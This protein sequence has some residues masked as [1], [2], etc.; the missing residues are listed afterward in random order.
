MF[1]YALTWSIVSRNVLQ[2][3]TIEAVDGIRL[4]GGGTTAVSVM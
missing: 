4:K 2:H 1:N 3:A